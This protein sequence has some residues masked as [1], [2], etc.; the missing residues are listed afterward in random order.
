MQC[1]YFLYDQPM[2]NYGWETSCGLWLSY[3]KKAACGHEEAGLMV[4]EDGSAAC[5]WQPRA[6]ARNLY[7]GALLAA[8]WN[9]SSS[10]V[11]KTG[12]RWNNTELTIANSRALAKAFGGLDSMVKPR[13][14]GC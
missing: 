11:D 1:P 2:E 6:L 13:C 14:C 10:F 12:A 5:T 8:G 9:L 3:P 7:G 4:A